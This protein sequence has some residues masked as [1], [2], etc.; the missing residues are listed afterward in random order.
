MIDDRSLLTLGILSSD[1]L[2]FTQPGK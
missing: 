2:I 1:W